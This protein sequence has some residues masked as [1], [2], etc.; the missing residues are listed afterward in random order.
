MTT[1]CSVAPGIDRIT[2]IA[3]IGG[4]GN[5][6]INAYVLHG[7]EPVLVES[8]TVVGRD[9]FMATL[10]T[11]INPADLRWLWLSHTDPDHIG[12]IPQLL[13]EAP[14]LKIITTFFGMGI[15]NL[16]IPVPPHRVHFV[17]PGE[18]INLADRTL[19]GVKPPAWDNPVTTGFFDDRTGVLFSSDC[20]GALLPEVAERAD[21]I[22][23]D[24]LR[25]GQVRWSTIDSPW[26]HSIDTGRFAH[27]L[28]DIRGIDPKW[29]LSG[30]LPPAPGTMLDFFL[31]SL[32]QV[33]HTAPIALP[34]QQML[35]AMLAQATAGVPG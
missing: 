9:D 24:T 21:H 32:A 30:H 29:V 19:T 11:V 14:D 6:P 5:L 18:R 4:F 7:A 28:D 27:V 16:S 15:L 12:A 25:A 22:D 13:E 17:N 23:R 20:F 1:A 26:L 10:R 2:S 3:E 8:G 34:D 31:E 33:P 35:E